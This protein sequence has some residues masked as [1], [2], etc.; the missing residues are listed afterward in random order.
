MSSGVAPAV[1]RSRVPAR[2]VALA[3]LGILAYLTLVYVANAQ[4]YFGSAPLWQVEPWNYGYA[5]VVMGVIRAATRRVT[6]IR[7]Q[8][9]AN[10]KSLAWLLVIFA[11][12]VGLLILFWAAVRGAW[13]PVATVA[14]ADHWLGRLLHLPASVTSRLDNVSAGGLP[15]TAVAV[16]AALWRVRRFGALG[17]YFGWLDWLLG[18]GMVA[19]GVAG[20]YITSRFLWNPQP[21]SRMVPLSLWAIPMF[22]LQALVNGIPEETLTRGY[23]MLQLDAFLRRPWLV[24]LVMIIVFDLYHLPRDLMY[25]HMP[26]F[27]TV[28]QLVFPRQPFGLIVGYSYWRSR[29]VTPGILFHTYTTLWA[30]P[31]L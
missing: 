30:W 11:V 25:L 22:L 8:L 13:Q 21:V 18:F 26:L 17:Y 14:G 16:G 9:P 1:S 6:R 7:P 5:A 3:T 20:A 4:G 24:M 28:W 2:T 23:L 31:F 29:S 12:Y 19:L 27:P 15:I 10:G